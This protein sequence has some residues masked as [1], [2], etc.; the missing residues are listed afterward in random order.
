[1]EPVSIE[2]CLELVVARLIDFLEGEE[3]FRNEELRRIVFTLR[4]LVEEL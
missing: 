2:H 4:D 1:M 3:V